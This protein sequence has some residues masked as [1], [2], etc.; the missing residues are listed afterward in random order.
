MHNITYTLNR[1]KRKTLVLRVT[2]EGTVEVRAPFHVPRREIDRFVASK[3]QWIKTRQIAREGLWREKEA[4]T[5]AYG[6]SVMVR[7]REYSLTAKEGTQAGFDGTCFY[8][9]PGLSSDELK[10]GVVRIY[11]I[12]AKNLLTDRADHYAKIT[13]LI[14]AAVKISNA[15]TR[16][17]SCSAKN[18]VNFSWRLVMAEDDVIDYVVVHELAH[19]REHNHS[20]RFWAVVRG[21]L[22]DYHLRQG[23]LKKLQQR[24]AAENWD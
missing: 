15:K 17:G 6:S 19:I 23:K 1:S 24:L 18:S 10:R 9:P 21:I 2:A 20:D 12:M 4:F 13:G 3:Q 14:P 7:G 22:P 5:L 11:R 16:W 8:L